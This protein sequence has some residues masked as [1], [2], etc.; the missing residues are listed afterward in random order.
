MTEV[1]SLL[2]FSKS[3]LL[4]HTLFVLLDEKWLQVNKVPGKTDETGEVLDILIFE[5]L[6]V[7]VEDKGVLSSC[8]VML[9][10]GHLGQSL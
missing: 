6:A 9:F 1:I 3:N 5:A 4:N 8:G 10:L 7:E 2:D